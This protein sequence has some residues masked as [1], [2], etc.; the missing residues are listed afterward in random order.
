MGASLISG[1]AGSEEGEAPS[2]A[3]QRRS[4]ANNGG[5]NAAK[6]AAAATQFS[7][8]ETSG[9]KIQKCVP[10]YSCKNGAHF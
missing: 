6:Q 8:S 2:A 7:Y 10:E 4:G 1:R 5:A 9:E 3:R